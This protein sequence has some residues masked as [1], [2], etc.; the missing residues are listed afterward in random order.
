M[1]RPLRIIYEGAIYHVMNR[2]LNRQAIFKED[3]DRKNFL[4]LLS[5]LWERWS[6]EIYAYCLMDNH[7][8][9][10]LK[11]HEAKLSR[12]MR[13]LNGVYTQSFNRRHGRDGPLFR[14]RYKAL[15][16]QKEAYLH[17]VVRYIHQNPVEAKLVK[18]A[19][20]YPWSS[21]R[22]Y[23]RSR[24]RPPWLNTK[25]LLEY[26][27]SPKVFEAF[28]NQGNEEEL[29]ASY[30]GKGWPLVLGDPGFIEKLKE[31]KL[32]SS[33][34][35][36]RKERI[37][38]RPGLGEVLSKVSKHYGV[39]IKTLV[40]SRRGESNEA[41]KVAIYLGSRLGDYSHAELAKHFGLNNARSISW[42]VSKV[43]REMVENR[44]LRKKVERVKG[45][46]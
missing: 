42:T 20:D 30:S 28:V 35:N 45:G 18:R 11:T 41:R 3:Q 10:C 34:E 1:A 2:G 33:Q 31:K 8:H 27:G 16:V 25:T 12:M 21:H 29:Q 4:Q 13:H 32:K 39:G 26:H 24:L 46:F 43:E 6:V 19:K 40:N 14:G 36:V 7:Y 23:L 38:V 15:V 22:E 17:Q 9:L 37:L 44:K 5:Q